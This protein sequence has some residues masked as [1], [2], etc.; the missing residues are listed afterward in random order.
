MVGVGESKNYHI[1]RLGAAMTAG[2]AAA[3][4]LTSCAGLTGGAGAVA[5]SATAV[6]SSSASASASASAGPSATATPEGSATPSAAA[7]EAAATKEQ[8]VPFITSATWDAKAGAL[9]VG[10]IVPV[11]V[12]RAG[13]CTLTAQR[14]GAALTVSGDAVATASYTGCPQL[15]L[16]DAG[17]TSGAWSVTVSY[18]SD[19]SAGTSAA[20]T[21][22]VG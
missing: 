1:A 20:R 2:L 11:V 22:T 17:L 19:D 16:K 12:E 5:P 14:D 15:V 8:V 13:T 4:L 7:T 6:A 21:V 9:D 18:D 3:T 10:A